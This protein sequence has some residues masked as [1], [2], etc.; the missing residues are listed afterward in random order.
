VIPPAK[1]RLASAPPETILLFML[2]LHFMFGRAAVPSDETEI[3]SQA[4]V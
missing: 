2:F 1:I 3:K 4:Y